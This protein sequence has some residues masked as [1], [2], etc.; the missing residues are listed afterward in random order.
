M[1]LSWVQSSGVCFSW[2]CE[3]TSCAELQRSAAAA[4]AEA[5]VGGFGNHQVSVWGT[6][7]VYVLVSSSNYPNSQWH[8]S[9]FI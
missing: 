5:Q 6:L 1:E 2:L 3:A 8:C 9:V 7:D 4:V